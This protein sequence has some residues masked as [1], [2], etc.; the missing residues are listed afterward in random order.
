[1]N[2]LFL[3]IFAL[4]IWLY[5]QNCHESFEIE[6]NIIAGGYNAGPEDLELE[7]PGNVAW[8]GY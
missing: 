4:L 6:P 1:M 3:I 2:I 8:S 7:G 5:V